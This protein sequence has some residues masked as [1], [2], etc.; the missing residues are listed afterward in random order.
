[1]THTTRSQRP[2]TPRSTLLSALLTLAMSITTLVGCD[3]GATTLG[4]QRDPT[5]GAFT[6][7]LPDGW[8]NELGVRRLPDQTGRNWVRSS[9][10][11]GNTQWF[12]GDP[13]IPVFMDPRAVDP[14]MRQWVQQS[15]M[16]MVPRQSA[17]RFAQ[18]YVQRSYG[19]APG[20]KITG[21]RPN[22]ELVQRLQSKQQEFGLQGDMSSHVL[23]F[24]YDSPTGPRFG[25]LW[26][27]VFVPANNSGLWMADTSGFVTATPTPEHAQL[28]TK[29]LYSQEQDPQWQARERQRSQARIAAN[30]ARDQARMSASNAAHQQRMA[31]QQASFQ[32]HQRRMGQ[33]SAANDAQYNSWRAGQNAQYQ[34]HQNYVRGIHD[35]TLV[36]G[37]GTMGSGGQ[38]PSY[39]VDAGYNHYYVDPNNQQY[40]GTDMPLEPGLVPDG[41]EEYSEQGGSW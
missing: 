16:G 20:F 28:F 13:S 41:Y 9:S 37:S 6:I 18:D 39:E 33:L 7:A 36:G 29:A 22:P 23:E 8:R 5:E 31:S 25:E 12:F 21:T 1:M 35:R 27:S 24:Q 38:G 34:S 19:Q 26:A 14:M 3:A 15:G 11:D 32:A 10:P 4:V 2:S 40:I 30:A 17:E